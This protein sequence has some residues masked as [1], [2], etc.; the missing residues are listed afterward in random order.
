MRRYLLTAPAPSRSRRSLF[1]KELV[2]H[3]EL[4]Y[5]LAGRAQLGVLGLGGCSPLGVGELAAA[6]DHSV[7]ERLG[8]EPQL[9][10]DLGDGPA[11]RDRV[12]GCLP[13]VL[14]G[15]AGPLG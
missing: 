8:V 10:G 11:A 9:P 13:T 14:V 5:A 2:L 15:E 4:A 12:V 1:F 6:D 3:L 7:V